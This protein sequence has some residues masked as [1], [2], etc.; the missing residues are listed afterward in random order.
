MSVEVDPLSS[1]DGTPVTV[2][3]THGQSQAKVIDAAVHELLLAI[4]Q[5]LIKILTILEL[6]FEMQTEEFTDGEN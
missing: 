4:N 3:P 1:A 2:E 5:N 6:E